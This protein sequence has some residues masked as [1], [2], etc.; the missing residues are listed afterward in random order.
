M[1]AYLSGLPGP[2]SSDAKHTLARLEL[3]FGIELLNNS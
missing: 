1:A 2:T 3:E